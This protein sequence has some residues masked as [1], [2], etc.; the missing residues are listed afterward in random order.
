MVSGYCVLSPESSALPAIRV[1]DLGGRIRP[2]DLKGLLPALDTMD[3][4][5]NL[6]VPEL[7]VASG[8][9]V[10]P[11][12]SMNYGDELTLQAG[13]GLAEIGKK[14]RMHV[15][16]RLDEL[17]LGVRAY[18]LAERLFPDKLPHS[19]APLGCYRYYGSR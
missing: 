12:I 6:S 18:M 4:I 13:I 1:T 7:T 8:E 15:R 14:E 11:E 3:D 17:K 9:V 2:S 5:L 10:L 16:L 19:N